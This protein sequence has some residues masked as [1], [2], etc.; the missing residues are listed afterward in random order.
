VEWLQKYGW[1]IDNL[2][3][4]QST[5]ADAGR[6]AFA[7]RSFQAGEVVVPVPLQSF[8]D[9]AVFQVTQPEQLYVNYCLQPKNSKMIFYPYG[10]IFNL[11][12]HPYTTTGEHKEP[13]V[14]LQWSSSNLSHA[15][16]V[17]FVV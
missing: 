7:R 5:I 12:N 9:R 6:G 15:F 17:G 16:V 14:H 2:R 3:V 11:I 4:G 13:N 1:C 8:K 10:P